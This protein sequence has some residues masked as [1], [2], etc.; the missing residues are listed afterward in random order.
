[1]NVSGRIVQDA[2]AILKDDPEEFEKIKS[3]KSTVNAA[4]RNVERKRRK[5]Q[6]KEE[7]KPKEG[8]ATR[9]KS[10]AIQHAAEAINIL[11]KIKETDPARREAFR[12]VKKW[13]TDN[14]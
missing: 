9:G 6:E 4:K 5:K 3:G 10:K 2:E 12:M 14:E 8:V 13:V 1:V 7:E 11:R